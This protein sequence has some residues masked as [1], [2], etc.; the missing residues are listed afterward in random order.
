[1]N[2]APIALRTVALPALLGLAAVA[3]AAEPAAPIAAADNRFGFALFRDL[4]RDS[5]GKNVMISPLSLATVLHMTANGARGATLDAMR[6]TLA[7][8]SLD[9]ATINAANKSLSADLAKA[10]PKV[11]LTIA[12]S[13][14]FA[15]RLKVRPEFVAANRASYDA[16]VESVDFGSEADTERA[17]QW[18]RDKTRGK[19][20]RILDRPDPE[21]IALLMN[22][23]YF[24]GVWK[25]QFDPKQTADAPFHL[26][27]A[28]PRKL[29]FMRQEGSFRHLAAPDV[30]GVYLP[31]GQGRLGM[32]L[33]LPPQDKK[34]AEF[35]ASLDAARLDAW[36]AEFRSGEGLVM[37][38]RFR[39]EFAG[40][41][42]RQLGRLGMAAAF[43]R[44]ADFSGI[45][46]EP[47]QLLISQVIHKTV[48]EVNEEGTVAAALSAV[49]IKRA[50]V[51][52]DRFV[53]RFDRPFVCLIR[54]ETSGAILFLAAVA[55]PAAL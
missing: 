34:L 15:K 19:I 3:C 12:N 16:A 37:L 41:L 13:L 10:D 21:L 31:Y 36:L 49:K 40:E 5:S 48:M 6:T 55:E 22:A 32:Y 20:D 39:V 25:T 38:P 53:L 14:W 42:S 11:E 26:E 7:L 18:V 9:L 24:K 1:M 45:A 29:P 52:P 30:S 46:G 35:A 54:D 23:V 2:R 44:G 51:N 47:G 50:S 4:V 33:L 27:A 8:G 43:G 17:N 28:A